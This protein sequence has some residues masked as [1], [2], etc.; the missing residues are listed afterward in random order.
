[1]VYGKVL[2]QY[3]RSNIETAGKLDLIIMCY[4]KTIQCLRQ[5]KDHI[6]GKEFE[7]KVRKVQKAM[8][9]ISAL[10]GCLDIE[11]G[12]E[13]AR[14]LDAIY[15]Y[16]NRR[17]LLGDIRRDLSI[18]DECVRILD[19]LKSAWKEISSSEGQEQII[20][21]GRPDHGN[22]EIAQIAA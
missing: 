12:G 2:N 14:N 18:F 9:I 19:E 1:M 3:K 8:D 20:S 7:K 16:L 11:K 21:M 6:K 13:I 10:Q 5:A 4:E 22:K 15:T 17:I